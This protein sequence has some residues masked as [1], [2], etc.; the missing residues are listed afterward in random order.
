MNK[1]KGMTLIELM[2]ILVVISILTAI[3]FPNFTD[4]MIHSRIKSAITQISK[5]LA[6]TRTY[7]IQN[8]ARVVMCPLDN[9]KKCKTDNTWA[10]GYSIFIDY[11][12]NNEYDDETDSLLRVNNL[13][14]IDD[15]LY[16]NQTVPIVYKPDGAVAG[17][18]GT[19]SYCPN[20]AEAEKYSKALVISLSGRVRKSADTD[21]TCASSS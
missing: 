20:R 5:D 15:T 18:I 3:A 7:A 19:L 6:F 10:G 16:F 2:I 17:S 9:D 13:I 1:K 21:I 8:E 14:G 12:A 4:M 11:N